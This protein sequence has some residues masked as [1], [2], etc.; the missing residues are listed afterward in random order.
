M[1]PNAAN[2]L[3]AQRYFKPL[4]GLCGLGGAEG[5]SLTEKHLHIL[6]HSLGLDKYGQGHPYRNHFVTGANT[7]DYPLCMGLTNR[8]LM[9]FATPSAL[10]GG[11]Y[12]FIV[13]PAG[14]RYV[15]ENSPKPP[16][17][18]ATQKRYQD[19]LRS[20]SSLSFIE[21]LRRAR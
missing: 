2:A 17:M 18:T 11:D 7:V 19:Y 10:T 9:S 3:G 4:T 13:T 20:D 21:Y 15:V 16:K 1:R 5:M 14:A 12:C 6:Q 8:G